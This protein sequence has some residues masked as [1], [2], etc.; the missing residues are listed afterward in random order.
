MIDITHAGAHRA[1]GG[2]V[3]EGDNVLKGKEF[4]RTKVDRDI[5]ESSWVF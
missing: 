5:R 2:S 3:E 4:N 1:T